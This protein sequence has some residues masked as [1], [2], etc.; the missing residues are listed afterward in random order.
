MIA[1]MEQIMSNNN[2]NILNPHQMMPIMSIARG[3]T[4]R[5]LNMPD[6]N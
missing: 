1:N 6:R 5:F 4:K 3:N 2:N